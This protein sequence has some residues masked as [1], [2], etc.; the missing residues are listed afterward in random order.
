MVECVWLKLSFVRLWLLQLKFVQFPDSFNS[1]FVYA[2]NCHYY[3][4]RTA[5]E[6]RSVNH[7]QGHMQTKKSYG[8]ERDGN[9]KS[10]RV[11][12]R[13]MY[14]VAPAITAQMSK[15][16]KLWFDAILNHMGIS[17]LSFTHF[18]IHNI[19]RCAMENLQFIQ[20]CPCYALHNDHARNYELF[21]SRNY[22]MQYTLQLS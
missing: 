18:H 19:I 12:E 14:N 6:R 17:R 3:S 11:S 21:D 16:P 4:S 22:R 10:E 15:M 5:Q 7:L 13:K 8:S 2:T 9:E 20:W 1:R